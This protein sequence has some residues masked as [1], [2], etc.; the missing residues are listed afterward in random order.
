MRDSSGAL[1]N[2][3]TVRSAQGSK[4]ALKRNCNCMRLSY[5]NWC[6]D[7][8]I[9]RHVQYDVLLESVVQQL[10][11]KFHGLHVNC[12]SSWSFKSSRQNA[13]VTVTCLQGGHSCQLSI[14]HLA[15]TDE[16]IGHFL[17]NSSFHHSIPR[18]H[19]LR[20]APSSNRKLQ[21]QNPP[22]NPKL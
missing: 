15:A 10:N 9:C 22:W 16:H 18:E 20:H 17:P 19:R 12:V 3:T 5:A 7:T 6:T 2:D 1:N 4:E 14:F 8:W 21:Q 13:Y 11:T